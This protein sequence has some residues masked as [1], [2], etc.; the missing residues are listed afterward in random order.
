M[1]VG[2]YHTEDPNGEYLSCNVAYEK[3]LAHNGIEFLRLRADYPDFWETIRGLDLFIIR[4]KHI[5]THRQLVQDILP[6]VE[7]QLG[8]R[9]F[10]DL[11]TCR[12]YDDKIKQ[13]LLLKPLGFPMVKSYIFWDRKEALEWVKGADYPLIF[14]LRGGAGAQNVIMIKNRQQARKLV[15]RMFGRGIYPE[16][17][18]HAGSLR[19]RHFNLYRELHH[20][21]GNLSRRSRGLDISPFWRV[22]KNYILFQE[23]IPDNTFDTRVTIIGDRGFIFRRHTRPGDFRASGSGRIDYD[24]EKVDLRCMEMAFKISRELKFQSM[25]YDFLFTPENEPVFCEISYTFQSR[26]I[27]DCPGYCDHALNWHPGHFWPE[28]L[29][30]VDALRLPDL[31]QPEL[32][33]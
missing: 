9:C 24:L 27:F 3:I 21:G 7:I 29:H 11:N 28:Y 1:K 6:A 32:D 22:H 15:N 17:F 30:L 25:A 12:H 19:F 5:D 33:Y 10:P 18:F 16:K 4:W 2:I 8:S 14:K 13:Y 31:R 20:I 23:F 26:A